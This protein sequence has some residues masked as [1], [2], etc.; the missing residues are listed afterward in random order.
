MLTDRCVTGPASGAGQGR[1]APE[2]T[3]TSSDEEAPAGPEPAHDPQP[4][5]EPKQRPAAEP[6]FEAMGGEAG[7]ASSH[8][9]LASACAPSSSPVHTLPTRACS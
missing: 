4:A 1:P 6:K 9:P 5:A 2:N 8:A 3:A 7:S